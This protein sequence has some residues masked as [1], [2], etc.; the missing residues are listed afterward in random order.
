MNEKK[1]FRIANK[2]VE[3]I[4][5][6]FFCIIIFVGTYILLDI[7][8]VYNSAAT[9]AIKKV[10]PDIIT[11]DSLK[12]VSKDAI[13]WIEME[14]TNIDYPIMQSINNTDYLNKDPMGNYALSGSI[15]MD[16]RNSPDFSDEYNIVYGHH[17]AN[18]LM[19]GALDAFRDQKYFDSHRDG[20]LHVGD[21]E[22]PFKTVAFLI[23]KA[24]VDEVFSLNPTVEERIA[25]FQQYAD[26]KCLDDV[27]GNLIGL[28]TCKDPAT[29]DRTALI[30]SLQTKSD[31]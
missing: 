24:D 13:A 14:D 7:H 30:I 6:I 4:V 10:K 2:I 26:I 27:N 5:T 20:I 11:E 25:Y 23:T 21:K 1:V 9:E 3:K 22:Y 12:G 28:T 18:G 17:M 15:F 16:F 31:K 29:T 8:F 19:F